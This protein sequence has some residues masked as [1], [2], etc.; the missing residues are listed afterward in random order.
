[1]HTQINLRGNGYLTIYD[2]GSARLVGLQYCR[3]TISIQ[4]LTTTG[5]LVT[6]NISQPTSQ[7][8]STCLSLPGP[9]TVASGYLP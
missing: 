5:T 7:V 4:D 1:M 3:H 6:S 8:T 2:S 9:L